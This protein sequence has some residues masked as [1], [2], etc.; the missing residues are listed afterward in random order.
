MKNERSIVFKI[1]DEDYE[2]ILTT[3]AAKSIATR[4]NG[5]ENL[6]ERLMKAE[7]FKLS[8]DEIVWLL[9]L[10]ANQSVLIYNLKHK[11]T[12]K[13]FLTEEEVE[14]LTSPIELAS[15]KKII[16][17]CILKSIDQ[18]VIDEIDGIVETR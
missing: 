14:L 12:P 1:G 11:D 2:L 9:T 6:S 4:Y 18:N 5:I 13:D 8:L 17:E 16:T 15:Y 3:K 10:L 7:N